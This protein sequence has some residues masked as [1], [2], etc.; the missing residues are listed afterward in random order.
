MF[1]RLVVLTGPD[2]DVVREAEHA[3]G[4]GNP[5]VRVPFG[6]DLAQVLDRLGEERPDA[7]VGYVVVAL[8]PARLEERLWD[9]REIDEV[10]VG[11]HLIDALACADTCVLPR[12]GDGRGE[13]LL[14]QLAPR[15]RVH[16]LGSSFEPGGYD[17]DEVIARC[18]PGAVTVPVVTESGPF[19]TV[20]ARAR[21]PLHPARLAAAMPELAAGS[22]W[23]RGRLWIASVPRRRVVWCGVGPHVAFE[24]GGVWA[25]DRADGEAVPA[26]VALDWD[27]R[28][29][30]RGTVLAFTGDEVDEQQITALLRDCELTWAEFDSGPPGWSAYHDPM[31]LPELLPA[32]R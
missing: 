23:S 22:V 4:S 12:A 11:E 3:V 10:L 27:H 18:A 21:L 29:A 5:V 19:R 14:S 9:R 1:P 31:G 32:H 25:A 13:H 6:V 8:D 28:F 7:E 24:D 2:D 17:V 15:A 16:R 30:D 26:A 20:L